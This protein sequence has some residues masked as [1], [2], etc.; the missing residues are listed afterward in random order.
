MGATRSVMLPL[1]RLELSTWHVLRA[2]DPDELDEED[3]E[4]GDVAPTFRPEKV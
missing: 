4:E 2:A 1:E 3:V